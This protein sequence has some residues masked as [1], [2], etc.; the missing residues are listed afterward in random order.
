MMSIDHV[1]LLVVFPVEYFP[2]HGIIHSP[3]VVIQS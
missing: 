2:S 1:V 3:V